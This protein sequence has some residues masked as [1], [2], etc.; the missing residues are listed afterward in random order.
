MCPV[1]SRY[2]V[3]RDCRSNHRS[4]ANHIIAPPTPLR[5]HSLRAH[6]LVTT[7]LLTHTPI[8]CCIFSL[9]SP[10]SYYLHPSLLH[11]SPSAAKDPT[12]AAF[13]IRPVPPFSR[14]ITNPSS[15]NASRYPPLFIFTYAYFPPRSSHSFCFTFLEP[16]S[17]FS[18]V[19][20]TR[21]FSTRTPNLES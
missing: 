8:R 10:L 7:H 4:L 3:V 18:P 21:D 17:S 19:Q 14:P 15:D 16:H 11:P 20:L 6:T 5:P 1:A 2:F 13:F 9:Q 12:S